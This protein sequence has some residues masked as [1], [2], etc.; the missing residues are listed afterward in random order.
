MADPRLLLCTDMDRTIIPN[1]HQPEHEDARRWFREFCADDQVSLVYVTGRHRE[2]VW[3]AIAA[4]DLPRPDYAITDVGSVIYRVSASAWQAVDAW[5]REIA[6]DWRG[7][8]HE[9]LRRALLP[10]TE[11]RLQEAAKQNRFKLSYYLDLVHDDRQVAGQMEDILNDLGIAYNLIWSVDEKSRVGLIDILP[12]RADKLHGLTFL[13]QELG[14]TEG[15]LLFAGDSGNDLAVL[16]SSVPAVLVANASDDVRRAA[17]C[18]AEEL[19]NSERLFLAGKQGWPAD[20]NYCTGVLQ[21]VFHF[22]PAF[23]QLLQR[24]IR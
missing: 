1:G 3:E 6:S 14:Y 19:G 18:Q 22:Y 12:G 9:E 23:R 17:R 15:N 5:E 13:R 10:V 8:G 2:L 16:R 4:Y 11:L 7:Y 21:G 24:I 20:G